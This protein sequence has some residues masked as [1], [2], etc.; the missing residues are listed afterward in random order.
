MRIISHE[1]LYRDERH[2]VSFP[3]LSQM[4][5]GRIFCGFRHALD[6]QKE[7][8]RVT[9]V[10]PTAK[11]GYLVSED[12][13]KTFGKEFHTIL[14]SEMSDQDPC[15]NVLSDGR[16]IASYFQWELVP[17]G[18]G[19][20]KWGKKD[21][22]RYG[23]SL[24]DKYDCFHIGIA[25][26]ISDD[27]CKTWKHYPTLRAEGLPICSGVRGNIIELDD[28][29][30]IMPFYGCLNYGESN[31]VGLLK[32]TDRGESWNVLSVMAFDP[33]HNKQ[34]LEPNIFRTP[35]GKIV[36]LFRT[37]SDWMKPNVRF[38][39]TYLNLHIA[40]SYDNGATFQ[41]VKEIDN[42]WTS[43]PVHALQ[44]K[45]GKVLLSYGYRKAPYGIRIRVCNSELTDIHE[46]EEIILRDDA[47]NGDLGYPHAIQLDDGEILVCYYIPDQDG[48]R[49]IAVT[50]LRED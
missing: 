20:R 16:V 49:T 4:P 24:H 6:R 37:Q 5:D 17:I 39:D 9:H 19:A 10:D 48:I 12:G 33:G 26:S 41:P 43:S 50:R 29:S 11:I 1:T 32:S 7:Y 15:I 14:D 35:S 21:F 47:P 34:F 25:Y 46:S 22:E 3:C 8:G 44:L 40:E 42:C 13:G 36:G 38:D 27:N 30:L 45:S 23:R 28:G 2:Y 18:K 31:R